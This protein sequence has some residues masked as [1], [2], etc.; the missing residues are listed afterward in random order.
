MC[1]HRP[2]SSY[3]LVESSYFTVSHDESQGVLAP[4][5]DAELDLLRKAGLQGI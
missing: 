2:M 1:E 4:V 3:Y 5:T